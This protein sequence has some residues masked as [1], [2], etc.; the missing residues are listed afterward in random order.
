MNDEIRAHIS[1]E[2]NVMQSMIS[3][4]QMVISSMF[5]SRQISERLVENLEPMCKPLQRRYLRQ[6][7]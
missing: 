2:L 1:E 4:M 5:P 6:I 3:P 7:T